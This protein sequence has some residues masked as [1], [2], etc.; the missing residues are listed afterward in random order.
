MYLNV[1]KT[2]IYF[3]LT[4]LSSTMTAIT[5]MSKS[6]CAEGAA[7]LNRFHTPFHPF[8]FRISLLSFRNPKSSRLA[9]ALIVLEAL[10]FSKV[11]RPQSMAECPEVLDYIQMR[12]KHLV[13][14]C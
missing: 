6:G 7:K 5:C 8:F 10:A 2:V 11:I 14:A 3:R 1:V 13:D 4:L 9:A 12:S